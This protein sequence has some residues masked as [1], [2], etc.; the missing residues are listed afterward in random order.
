MAP[1]G[2][3]AAT[4]MNLGHDEERLL[5]VVRAEGKVS[6]I[7]GMKATGRSRQTV[8][9][10]LA[11]LEKMGLLVWKGAGRNDPRGHYVLRTE[12]GN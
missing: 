5:A 11:R 7:M 4:G 1:P 6:T 10:K 12:G 8:V 2:R 9:T 3:N